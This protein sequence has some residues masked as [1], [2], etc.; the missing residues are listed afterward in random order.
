MSGHE[1]LAIMASEKCRQHRSGK[2][3][4]HLRRFVAAYAPLLQQFE[5]EVTSNTAEIL[6]EVIE[7]ELHHDAN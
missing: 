2:R 7:Q 6:D 4:W 5:L 3:W 1:K